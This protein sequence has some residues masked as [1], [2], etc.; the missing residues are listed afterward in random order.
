MSHLVKLQLAPLP[1]RHHA[2]RKRALREMR[3]KSLHPN[4]HLRME[5][6][7]ATNVCV[8]VFFQVAPQV[9]YCIVFSGLKK[10]LR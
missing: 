4:T 3:K 8:P 10:N 1:E 6:S 2:A 7:D 5:L 9:I